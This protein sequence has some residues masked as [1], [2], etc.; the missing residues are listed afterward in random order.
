MVDCPSTTYQWFEGMS[1]R[2]CVS[3]CLDCSDERCIS[4]VDG[5]ILHETEQSCLSVIE[6][7]EL[8]GSYVDEELCRLCPT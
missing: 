2:R 7:R 1:C 6:C 3:P 4:C 5:Y 8:V